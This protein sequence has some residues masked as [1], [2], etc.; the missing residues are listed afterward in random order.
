MLHAQTWLRRVGLG[1]VALAAASAASPAVAASPEEKAVLA[2]FQALLDGIAA[3]N[4]AAILKQ[5]LPEGSA[6][7][8]RNGKPVQLRLDAF[9]ERVGKGTATTKLEERIY[10]PLIRI[11]D[12]LAV[13]WTPY[14]FLVDG[15]VDHC[16]TDIVNLVKT[17]GRWLIAGIAD[18]SRKTCKP[19]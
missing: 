2:P 12:D 19:R 1:M 10:D 6:I 13:I 9:A 3:R 16:G 11:D 17:D 8:I 7:L 14:D 18:N 5:V 4:G 15:Q